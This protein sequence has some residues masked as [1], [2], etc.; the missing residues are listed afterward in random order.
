MSENS[1][2]KN[3]SAE[4]TVSRTLDGVRVL[5][6]INGIELFGHERSNIEVFRTLSAMG[7]EVRVGVNPIADNPVRETLVHSGIKTFPV[8]FGPQWSLQ[9]VKRH[10]SLVF[11]NFW[12]VWRCSKAFSQTVRDFRPTHFH[13]GSPLAYSYLV[14]ALKRHPQ[15]L[16]YRMGDCPPLPTA[17]LH[18][19]IWKSAMRRTNRLVCVSK[20]V[21][22]R[23]AGGGRAAD[24]V[25]YNLAPSFQKGAS[26][27]KISNASKATIRLL[28][29]GAISEQ[30]GVD[31]LIKAV[32]ELRKKSIPLQ[33]D[34]VGGSR[35]DAEQRARLQALTRTLGVGDIVHFVG[36]VDDTTPYYE[37]ANIH[38]HPAIVEEALGNVVMEA[39]RS[40][41]PSVVFPSG[42]LPEIV[43][44]QK[45]GYLC[46]EKTATALVEA[47]E[48][49]VET[50]KRAHHLGVAAQ[51]A[52]Q[53]RFGESRFYRQW[54]DIYTHASDESAA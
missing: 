1:G 49:M 36:H 7:A 21:A 3:D 32:A 14:L 44:H 26:E 6:A 48:W 9:W 17:R 45:D 51:Q 39:K 54:A 10:P 13:L 23:A 24:A 33:V 35:Y 43:R 22:D 52:Y 34:L 42:G 37:S 15:P 16:V 11:T 8:P 18:R 47:I 38:V 25:I 4:H 31:I 50:P 46:Q 12:K 30:K 28:Y 2:Q 5:G 41:I 29:V 19:T 27:H 40:G 53:S 20:F